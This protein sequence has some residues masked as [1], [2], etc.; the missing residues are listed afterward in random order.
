[1]SVGEPLASPAWRF[2][3]GLWAVLAGLLF[4]A[5][6]N[7]LDVPFLFDDEPAIT[8]N[9]R[10]RSL[11]PF[12]DHGYAV[13]ST[14]AGR[15]VVR[16]TL[17]LNYRLGGLEPRGYHLVNFALHLA[18]SFLLF[19]LLWRLL[20]APRTPASLHGSAPFLAG[21]VSALWLVHPLLTDAVTYVIQRTELLMSFFLLVTLLCAL[22]SATGGRGR[23]LAVLACFLGMGSKEAMAMA[24]LLVVL[25]ERAFVF[26]SFRVAWKARR[27]FYLALLASWIPLALIVASGPRDQTAGWNVGVPWWRYLLTQGPVILH[28]LELVFWPAGLVLDYG[29]RLAEGP[30]EWLLG[31]GVVGA[32]F[33]A[34]VWACVKRPKLGFAG[35]CFFLILAPSSSIVPILTEVGAERRMYLPLAALLSVLFLCLWWLVAALTARERVRLGAFGTVVTLSVALAAPAT[36][37]RN[38]VFRSELAIWQDAAAKRPD[39]P[40]AHNN[41]GR[42]YA[43]RG[44]LEL[45]RQH[46]ERAVALPACGVDAYT[47]LGLVLADLGRLEEAEAYLRTVVHD[48]P[49]FAQG[50]EYL[51]SILNRR[52][53][54]ADARVAFETCLRLGRRSAGILNDYART[55]FKLGDLEGAIARLEEAVALEPGHAIA[56]GNL[57]KMR[58]LRGPR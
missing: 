14:E 5:Y 45:A 52:E 40:G 24:P 37:A 51:G 6:R 10:I 28:Y 1:M 43:K 25:M 13:Q 22:R 35:A 44:E 32:L 26:G 2:R 11:W 9:P 58:A 38:E 33:L 34:S 20:R 15:P 18:S 47:N 3:L 19:E 23:A 54:W 21:A 7:A 48:N 41:L 29:K 4:L 53:K 50:H 27:G 39:N 8:A 55:L 56:R 30:R 57:E 17:A 31:V 42:V 36:I 16:F 12:G 49:D 46:F